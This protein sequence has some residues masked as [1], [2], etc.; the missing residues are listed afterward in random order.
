MMSDES[1][2]IF[3]KIIITIVFLSL[4]NVREISLLSGFTDEKRMAECSHRMFSMSPG[5]YRAKYI[6]NKIFTQFE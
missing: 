2:I 5:K 4:Q 1:H 6:D 3:M